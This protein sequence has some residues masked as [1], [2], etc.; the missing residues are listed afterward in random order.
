M[1]KFA[2]FNLW[3]I[4]ALKSDSVKNDD[5]MIFKAASYMWLNTSVCLSKEINA[6]LSLAFTMKQKIILCQNFFSE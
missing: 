6:F 5:N 4:K 2:L 1:T 3:F